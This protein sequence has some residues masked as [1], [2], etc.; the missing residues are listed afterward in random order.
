MNRIV[1]SFAGAALSLAW[2]LPAAFADTTVPGMRL[3]KM[4]NPAFGSATCTLPSGRIVTWD[5]LSVDLWQAN[6][7]FLMNLGS[8]P[9]FVF[10]NFVVSTPDGSAV[11]LGES[12]HMDVFLAQTDGSGMTPIANL[13]FNYAAA[14]SPAGELYVSAALNGFGFGNDIVRVDLAP[15]ASTVVGHVDGPSGPL[16]FKANGDLYYATQVDTFPPPLGATDVIFWTAAQVANATPLDNAN[17][18]L[19]GTGFDGGASLDFDPA[20]GK[21]FM[22]ETNFSIALNRIVQVKST[23]ALSPA[24]VVAAHTINSLEVINTGGG[25]ASCDPYQ[26]SD[27]SNVRY[28]TTDFATVSDLG[29]LRPLRPTLTASGPGTTGVGAVTFTLTDGVPDGTMFLFFCDQSAYS[30]VESTFNFPGFLFHTGLAISQTRRVPFYIPTDAEGTG[31]VTFW[32]AGDLT[33]AYAYQ[34]FVGTPLATFLG[35][36]TSTLF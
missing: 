28:N 30:P 8:V 32:N 31:T 4:A 17:A 7:V 23:Q 26:P 12:T 18:T 34:A 20:T 35:A 10:P 11:V 36:S 5:G 14:F 13:R 22:A 27:G 16:A 1:S 9:S 33:N 21:L 19:F 3:G 2:L 29:L 15:P 6:G 25:S 24:L